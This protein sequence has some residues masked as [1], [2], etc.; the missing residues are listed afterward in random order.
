LACPYFMPLEKLEGGN[1]QHPARLPLGGG[2]IGHCTA[3]GH[4]GEVPAQNILEA[5]CNLGYACDCA[6]APRERASDAVRFAV[7][8]PSIANAHREN[9]QTMRSIRIC[10]VCERNHRPIK[11][12]DLEFD[13]QRSVWVQSDADPRIQQMAECFLKSYLSRKS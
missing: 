5:F 11:R 1:W 10:F 9:E 3:P 2:W 6:W 13:L 12:G 4:K 8:A 7:L